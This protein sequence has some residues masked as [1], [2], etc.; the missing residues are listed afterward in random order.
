[1]DGEWLFTDRRTY[2]EQVEGREGPDLSPIM[3]L[4]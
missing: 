1:V 2:N 4:N 3:G